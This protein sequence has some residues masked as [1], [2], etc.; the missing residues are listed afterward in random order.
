[1]RVAREEEVFVCIE[2]F[3]FGRGGIWAI[4]IGKKGVSLVES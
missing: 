3:F 2:F 1:M 4:F